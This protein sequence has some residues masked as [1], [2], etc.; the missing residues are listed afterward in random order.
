MSTYYLDQI[1]S[2]IQGQFDSAKEYAASAWA[3]ASAYLENLATF[4]KNFTPNFIDLDFDI[5]AINVENYTPQRPSELGD[6]IMAELMGE[7]AEGGSGLD[8]DVEQAIYDRAQARQDITNERTYDEALSFFASRGWVVP[9]G[10]LDAKL[11]EAKTEQ[12]RADAEL[13]KDV[14]I[15][16]AELAQQNQHFIIQSALAGLGQEVAL[17]AADVTWSTAR[18][19]AAIKSYDVWMQHE[20]NRIQIMLREAEI[21]LNILL[22]NYKVQTEAIRAGAQIYAQL[23]ASAMSSVSAAA[24]MSYHGGYDYNQNDQNQTIRSYS[25]AHHFN[26]NYNE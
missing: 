10:A 12:T 1:T 17:Y 26:Y 18:I 5:E 15:K 11:T 24:Q 2:T 20:T 14:M 25:E 21:N 4:I 3:Y 6:Q 16:Q 19:D 9:P 7:L 8:E 13:S 22:E 23:A